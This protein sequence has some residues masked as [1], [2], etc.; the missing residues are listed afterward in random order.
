MADT[1]KLVSLRT[2]DN[3]LHKVPEHLTLQMRTI[4]NLL[5]CKI[6]SDTDTVIPLPNVSSQMLEFVIKWCE[7]IG[8]GDKALGSMQLSTLLT[9]TLPDLEESELVYDLMKAA[10]YLEIESLLEATTQHV[11]DEINNCNSLES[12]CELFGL[13]NDIGPD[14]EEGEWW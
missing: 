12:V 9:A 6:F 8:P 14:D 1:Q 2:C 5:S 3:V 4:R 11:A 7:A 10:N 13:E